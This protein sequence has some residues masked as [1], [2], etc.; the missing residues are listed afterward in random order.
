MA[1]IHNFYAGPAVLPLGALERAQREMLD[2][3]GSGT[4]VMETSHRSKEYDA[5]HAEAIQLVRDLLA[6]PDNYHILFLQGGASLQFCMVPMNLLAAEQTADYLHTGTWAKKA[7][8]EAKHFGQVHI[9]YDGE[10]D[11]LT[12]VPQ[13]ADLQLTPGARYVHFTSNNTIKGT[14]Y[15]TFPDAGDVPLVCDMSS[16]FMWRPFDVSPFGII[17]AGAQK[18][19]GP[20]GVTVV[21][22]RDDIVAQCRDDI[23]T[24]LKYKTHVEKNSLFNTPPCFNVY[25][26]RNVLQI[27][28]EMGG[29]Q[30]I[31]EINR[32]KAGLIYET[33]D[34]NPDFFRAPVEKESRSMMN[35]VFRLPSEELEAQFVAQGK[36]RGM[37]GLKGHRSVGGIR[38][39]TYNSC[40]EASVAAV[41]DFM[42]EF[43]K[44]HG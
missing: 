25:M 29:L 21:L 42:K 43:A 14:Q 32:R 28:Q 2:W 27:F 10:A 40:P 4:S 3:E 19:V 39:S 37:V 30:K 1:R 35:V 38:I 23:P 11:G 17:Y 33:I 20:S 7:I 5:L 26:L 13:Q 36:Q 16:D 41:V 8:A 22:I 12:R 15:H 24:L 31:E 9:A 34:R 44:A 6:V 18:N